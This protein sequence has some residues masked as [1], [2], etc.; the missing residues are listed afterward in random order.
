MNNLVGFSNK[1][2]IIL[3]NYFNKNLHNS[4]IFSGLKGI[5]KKTFV[6][7]VINE[8]FSRSV[9]KNQITHHLNLIKNHTHPN[10]RYIKKDYD[11]KLN[12]EKNIISI[13]QIR[14]LKTFINESSF[15]GFNKFI[16]IDSSDDL[17]ISASNSLLKILEEPKNNTYIFL[18]S[19][20]FSS[21][22]PTIRS[23]CLK[24]KFKNHNFDNFNLI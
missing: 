6:F 15:D 9:N 5:G 18:I 16:I 21:L 4:L 11:V 23:R 3:E 22:L 2:K 14:K 1:K 24:F 7:D 13:E 19:H 17:S 20:Q 8:I 10:I 12:K